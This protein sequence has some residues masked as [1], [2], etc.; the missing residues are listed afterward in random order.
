MVLTYKEI[1]QY[2]GKDKEVI[3]KDFLNFLYKTDKIVESKINE[4]IDIV[5]FVET[6]DPSIENIEQMHFLLFNTFLKHEHD[7]IFFL[8]NKKSNFIALFNVEIKNNLQQLKK[9]M[10][11]HLVFFNKRLLNK[12]VMFFGVL[13]LPD[14]KVTKIYTLENDEM[15]EWN[16]T[17]SSII[18]LFLKNNFTFNTNPEKN[19]MK[20]DMNFNEKLLLVANKSLE[21]TSHEINLVKMVSD[22]VKKNKVTIVDI[23]VDFQFSIIPFEL[24]LNKY[25]NKSELIILNRVIGKQ[26]LQNFSDNQWYLNVFYDANDVELTKDK[27]NIT[28]IVIDAQ[29]LSLKKILEL[30]LL[31][32]KVILFGT[33]KENIVD[34]KIINLNKLNLDLQNLGVDVQYIEYN[35]FADLSSN[36]HFDNLVRYLFLP[37]KI[38]LDQTVSFSKSINLMDDLK[39]FLKHFESI[40]D[41]KY[42]K[43]MVVYVDY[44]NPKLEDKYLFYKALNSK[45]S[46]IIIQNANFK[47]LSYNVDYLFLMINMDLEKIKKNSFILSNIIKTCNR[48]QKE[49]IILPS[50]K[51]EY[52]EL[53][54]KLVKVCI[55]NLEKV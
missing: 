23:N 10:K 50:S 36:K 42:S 46:N 2:V 37:D 25:K 45:N 33:N 30:S 24:F 8:E 27:S 19:L 26:L 55:N 35:S 49:L 12:N 9:Q 54:D 44:N 16:G 18:K 4:I 11:N 38:K 28:G 43:Q 34:S 29:N 53:K 6:L 3:K 39:S 7:L 41:K 13:Y 48:T 14:K 17:L 20:L 32:K 40:D 22:S 1:I 51:K 31:Y 52:F 21:L 47:N 5:S 15:V